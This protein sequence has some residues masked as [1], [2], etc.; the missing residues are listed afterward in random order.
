[1]RRRNRNVDA[2][3]LVP[4]YG[5]RPILRKATNQLFTPPPKSQRRRGWF[6]FILCFFTYPARVVMRVGQGVDT[7]GWIMLYLH[8]VLGLWY[9]ITFMIPVDAISI[10][11]ILFMNAV[12]WLNVAYLIRCYRNPPVREADRRKKGTSILYLLAKRFG[13]EHDVPKDGD[14]QWSWYEGLTLMGVGLLCFLFGDP[15]GGFPLVF[16]GATYWISERHEHNYFE[17]FRNRRRA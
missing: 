14:I 7:I 6:F 9:I 13:Y 3:R 15:Y 12:I 17:R 16:I 4:L 5:D 2:L 1:M 10:P 8:N 11:L